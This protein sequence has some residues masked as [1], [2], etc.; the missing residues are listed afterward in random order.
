M[1]RA[2]KTEASAGGRKDDEETP[3]NDVSKSAG[4]GAASTNEAQRDGSEGHSYLERGESLQNIPAEVRGGETAQQPDIE[5]PIRQMLLSARMHRSHKV[6]LWP[7]VTMHRST[8]MHARLAIPGN[9]RVQAADCQRHIHGQVSA[10]LCL[11]GGNYSI[12]TM[13]MIFAV[14]VRVTI[15]ASHLLY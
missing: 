13:I 5:G 1:P 15:T 6:V 11:V 9:S 10:C 14:L 4:N 7:H 8:Q 12:N 2:D 3:E